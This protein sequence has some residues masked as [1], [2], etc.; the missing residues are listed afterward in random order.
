L[1]ASC[2]GG[3][4]KPCISATGLA[5]GTEG[6]GRTENPTT[7]RALADAYG[8]R[9]NVGKRRCSEDSLEVSRDREEPAWA[10]DNF[11]S[12]LKVRCCGS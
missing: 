10:I 6:D 11:L 8:E 12:T 5:G 1:R 2:L 7:C 3:E 9:G 4:L